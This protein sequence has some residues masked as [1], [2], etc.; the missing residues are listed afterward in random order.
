MRYLTTQEVARHC[1]VSSVTV[2]KWI[3]AG[4]LRGHRTPGGHRRVAHHDLIAFMRARRMPVPSELQA[5][6]QP[7]L[8]LV[9]DSETPFREEVARRLAARLPSA[10][11]EEAASGVEALVKVGR[12][13]PALVLFDLAFSD[14]DPTETCRQLPQVDGLDQ[15]FVV[16]VA[17]KPLAAPPPGAAAVVQRSQGA[18]AVVAAIAHT[19]HGVA[20]AVAPD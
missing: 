11:I 20:A 13:R 8:V 1:H 5:P 9:A 2:G 16:A 6:G 12:M 19:L 18:E 3:D 4:Y 10:Q 17:R 14:V 7:A 15:V